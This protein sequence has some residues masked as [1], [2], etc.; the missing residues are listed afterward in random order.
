MGKGKQ[1]HSSLK[2]KVGKGFE[3]P[4]L[5]Y[6]IFNILSM[7]LADKPL[8]RC[9]Y[10]ELPGK[11]KLKPQRNAISQQLKKISK[12]EFSDTLSMSE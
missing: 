4:C 5:W 7:Q 9:S 8:K 6:T 2:K 1:K 10:H 12:P 11:C 3:Q